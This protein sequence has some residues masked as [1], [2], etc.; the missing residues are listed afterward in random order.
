MTKAERI[1]GGLSDA[2]APRYRRI[3]KVLEERLASGAYPVGS[4]MPTEFE[5]AREFGTSRFTVREALR[6]LADRGH[7]ERRQG[8]GTRVVSATA[9]SEYVQSFNSLEELLQI[10]LETWFVLH[11]TELVTLD[12]TLAPRVG[13][14]AGDQWYR[15]TG[16]RW[17]RPGGQVICYIESFI[18][19][20]FAEVV[21]RLG[22]HDGP[23]FSLLQ[24]HS[25]EVI[26]EIVQEI[27]AAEMP[28][29]VAR[30]LG[31]PKSSYALQLLRRYMTGDEVIIASFNWHPA[32]RMTYTM[33]IQ[34]NGL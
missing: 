21:N 29:E 13:G 15:V 30:S 28:A 25:E 3:Q 1:A 19:A 2:A 20:R 16:V 18:P 26:D 32:D 17:T 31:L 12:A 22:D 10:A 33:Q 5:L 23:F 34:R 6:K 27:R 14:T 11:D 7:I 8:H 4:L 9:R 24:S